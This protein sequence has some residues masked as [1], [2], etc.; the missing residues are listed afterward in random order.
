M[1]TKSF[2]GGLLPL[3][4][5][6][7]VGLAAL[8]LISLSNYWDYWDQSCTAKYVEQV[9]DNVFRGELQAVVYYSDIDQIMVKGCFPWDPYYIAGCKRVFKSREPVIILTCANAISEMENTGE[10]QNQSSQFI[11]DTVARN[12]GISGEYLLLVVERKGEIFFFQVTY[13]KAYPDVDQALF[14]K[15]GAFKPFSLF[16]A[17]EIDSV[18]SIPTSVPLDQFDRVSVYCLYLPGEKIPYIG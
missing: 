18:I 7:I 1:R 9:E 13:D 15:T 4:V 17:L 12:E 2:L 11:A 16:D 6:I 3:A 14:F 10:A 8:V 5:V